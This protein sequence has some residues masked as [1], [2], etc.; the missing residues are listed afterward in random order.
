MHIQMKKIPFY[1][2]QGNGNDF[3]IIATGEVHSRAG[4]SA[5]SPGPSATAISPWAPT[6][7]L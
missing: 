7:S 5:A 1:K 6:G 3:I 2:I 4:T